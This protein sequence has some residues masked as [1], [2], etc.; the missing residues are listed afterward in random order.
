MIVKYE[1]WRKPSGVNTVLYATEYFD[2]HEYFW[3][4][5]KRTIED[6][7]I[8]FYSYPELLP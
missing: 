8:G 4:E 6:E 7:T 3:Y 1:R 5:N 2:D